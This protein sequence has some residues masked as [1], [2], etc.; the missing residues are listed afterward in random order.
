MVRNGGVKYVNIFL[1][2]PLEGEVEIPPFSGCRTGGED[3]APLFTASLSGPGDAITI[4]RDIP[5]IP[6]EP[7][8][9]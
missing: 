8:M 7:S 4:N 2:G 9:C 3:L 1:G 6:S 5:C